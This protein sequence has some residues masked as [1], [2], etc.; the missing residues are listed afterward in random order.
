MVYDTILHVV[1]NWA[2]IL[3]EKIE[4]IR[5]YCDQFGQI[6]TTVFVLCQTKES[7]TREAFQ[8]VYSSSLNFPFKQNIQSRSSTATPPGYAY[9]EIVGFSEET[10]VDKMTFTIWLSYCV[11]YGCVHIAPCYHYVLAE[12]ETDE[13]KRFLIEW[14]CRGD[15]RPER[16]IRESYQLFYDKWD[17]KLLSYKSV[18]IVFPSIAWW[19]K[20]S[21]CWLWC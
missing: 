6:F 1:T 8:I 3:T 16:P 7:R 19:L 4:K 10:F 11:C 2:A 21:F 14:S 12:C 17:T 20:V 13:D 9:F 18:Y 15:A 5:N